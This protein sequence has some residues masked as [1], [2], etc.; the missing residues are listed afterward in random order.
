MW[1]REYEVCLANAGNFTFDELYKYGAISFSIQQRAQRE[2]ACK[3]ACAAVIAVSTESS[4][5]T[6][7]ATVAEAFAIG[8]SVS[9]YG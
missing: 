3:F 5:N 1:I 7:S 6:S 4:A 9:L 8:A 2:S